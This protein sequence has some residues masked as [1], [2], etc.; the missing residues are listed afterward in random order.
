MIKMITP[1]ITFTTIPPIITMSLCQAGFDLN[2]QGCGSEDIASTSIDSSIIPDIFT[3]PPNGIAPKEYSVSP[4]VFPQIFGG[5]PIEN[6][7]T[8]IP[9]A[10]AASKC[11]ISCKPTKIESPSNS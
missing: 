5:N 4:N 7:S 10:L 8:L 6:F 3:K 1:V 9:K 2:S 11:P